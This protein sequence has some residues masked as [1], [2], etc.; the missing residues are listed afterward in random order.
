MLVAF[1][2]LAGMALAACGQKGALRLPPPDTPAAAPA[3]AASASAP[4]SAAS[5]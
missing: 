2:M 3:P 1:A 5:R 4:A